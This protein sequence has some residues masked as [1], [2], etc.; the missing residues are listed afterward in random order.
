MELSEKG[1]MSDFSANSF[2]YTISYTFVCIGIGHNP[3]KQKYKEIITP[4][5]PPHMGVGKTAC[6]ITP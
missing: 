1:A 6:R 2:S 3:T 4:I 5:T